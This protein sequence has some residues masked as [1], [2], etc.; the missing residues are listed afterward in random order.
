ADARKGKIYGKLIKEIT[1]AART[2][3]G[4]PDGNPRLKTA[5]LAARAENMP[6]DNVERAIKRGTGEIEGAAFEE[7]SLEGYGPGGV[8]LLIDCATDNRNRTISDVRS[9]L[10]KNG[11]NMGEAGCVAWA[12]EKKG[13]LSV[14]KSAIAED[15]LIEAALDAGADDVQTQSDSY[16]IL[17]PIDAFDKVKTALE[18]KGIKFDEAKLARIPQN[19]VR[20]EGADAK[21]MLDLMG[22]LE[23]LDDVQN[24]WSNFDIDE[25][26]MA[27]LTQ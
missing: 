13:Y 26:L 12:F 3:G 24:V 11:G 16:D 27:E 1:I 19:T 8:A 22:Y 2:G 23:D 20:L 9:T 25:K 7:M 4:N 18:G 5:I 10:T 15:A 17:T 14:P 21:K 6:N